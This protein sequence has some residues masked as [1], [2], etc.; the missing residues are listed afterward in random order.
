M[1]PQ[2]NAVTISAQAEEEITLS[3]KT[4]KIDFDK[5]I[6]TGKTDGL[7]ALQQSIFTRLLTISGVYDIFSAEYGLPIYDLMEQS[8]PLIYVVLCEKIT[9]TLLQDDRIT[10]VSNFV[11]D[12]SGKSVLVSFDVASIF[13]ATT[14]EGVEINV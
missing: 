4:W 9:A 1:I 5:G 14:I 13:G 6:V 2:I 3:S 11:F 7:E 12:Q 8:A 10:G